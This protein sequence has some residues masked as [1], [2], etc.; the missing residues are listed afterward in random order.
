M[1]NLINSKG[2]LQNIDD[3]RQKLLD[4]STQANDIRFK[5]KLVLPTHGKLT[6][7]ALSDKFY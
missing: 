5:K 2:Q 7:D 3:Y 1:Y 4:W 6:S